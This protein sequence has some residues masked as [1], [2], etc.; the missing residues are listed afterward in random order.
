MTKRYKELHKKIDDILW[1]DWDPIGVND[2]EDVRDEYTSYVPYIVNLKMNNADIQ[3]ISKHLSQL[4]T[5]SMGMVGNEE[6]C[7]KIAQK[8]VEL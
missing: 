8:I 3:K 6:R 5:V 1:N 4:E 2:I 7:K